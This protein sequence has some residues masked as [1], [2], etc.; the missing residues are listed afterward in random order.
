ML[1]R[2]NSE[3]QTTANSQHTQA[4][5]TPAPAQILN[6]TTTQQTQTEPANQHTNLT[7]QFTS[8]ASQTSNPLTPPMHTRSSSPRNP[9]A[10]SP[11]LLRASPRTARPPSISSRN[12]HPRHPSPTSPRIMTNNINNINNENTNGNANNSTTQ[13]T[14][15][16]QMNSTP[17]PA[18][19]TLPPATL[20]KSSS[21]SSLGDAHGI[22]NMDQVLDYVDTL[23]DYITDLEQ[24]KRKRGE[25][26]PQVL[27][28]ASLPSTFKQRSRAPPPASPLS[29]SSSS[30]LSSRPHLP[31]P[32]VP[33]LP[34]GTPLP[35]SFAHLQ[36]HAASAQQNHSTAPYI[37]PTPRYNPAFLVSPI[38]SPRTDLPNDTTAAPTQ[39][40][41]QTQTQEDAAHAPYFT[42]SSYNTPS[43]TPLSSS[44]SYSSD[45]PYFTLSSFPSMESIPDAMLPRNAARGLFTSSSTFSRGNLDTPSPR[46]TSSR[47]PTRSYTSSVAHTPVPSALS[48]RQELH[49]LQAQIYLRQAQLAAFLR[50][51]FRVTNSPLPN[52]LRTSQNLGPHPPF[53]NRHFTQLNRGGTLDRERNNLLASLYLTIEIPE[54]RVQLLYGEVAVRL[55]V[56]VDSILAL[57]K[58][59]DTLVSIDEDVEDGMA[60]DVYLDE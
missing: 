21:S 42:R 12:P 11:N 25:F 47:A 14:T 36:Q 33:R 55:E 22:M 41:V 16:N 18:S 59:G 52:G 34:L 19:T 30:S 8:S 40:Q 13:S 37:I 44:R 45:I 51:K 1:P 7:S 46:S 27:R 6:Y 20:L 26:V 54:A 23:H 43:G 48:L 53:P 38:P 15:S 57:V 28:S 35:S 39:M 60:V 3:I 9:P 17:L 56:Q 49:E 58:N 31:L 2:I 4:T 50:I 29:S 32:P 24:D 10:A 5:Q